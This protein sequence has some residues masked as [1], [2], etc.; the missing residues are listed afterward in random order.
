MQFADDVKLG[1]DS[2]QQFGDRH[3]VDETADCR[4]TDDVAKHDRYAVEHL[5]QRTRRRSILWNSLPDHLKVRSSEVV[6]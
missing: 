1:V 3:R 6:K 5:V 2:I 4:E